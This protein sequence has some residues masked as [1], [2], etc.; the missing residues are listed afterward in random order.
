MSLT[1]TLCICSDNH[2]RTFS[3][4]DAFAPTDGIDREQR[5]G[6]PGRGKGASLKKYA[7]FVIVIGCC[8]PHFLFLTLESLE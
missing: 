4:Q 1:S 3:L 6:Q 5:A 2:F 8:R 7:Y